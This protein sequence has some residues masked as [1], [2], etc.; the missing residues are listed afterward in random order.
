MSSQQDWLVSV[1]SDSTA[2]ILQQV[3]TAVNENRQLEE[4]K[5]KCGVV[6]K[7]VLKKRGPQ[8]EA[9]KCLKYEVQDV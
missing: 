7:W 5:W 9:H 8:E 6:L 4:E 3:T 1:A 2:D